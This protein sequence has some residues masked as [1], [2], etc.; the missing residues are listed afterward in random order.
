MPLVERGCNPINEVIDYGS[1]RMASHE[2]LKITERES[3]PPSAGTSTTRWQNSMCPRRSTRNCSPSCKAP[4]VT[5]SARLRDVAY[6]FEKCG[7][8]ERRSVPRAW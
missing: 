2:H 5:S 6:R 8:E 1:N 7:V 4:R 3:G